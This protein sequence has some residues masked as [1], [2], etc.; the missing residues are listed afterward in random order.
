ML[1]FEVIWNCTKLCTF[2]APKIFWGWL[3]EILDLHYKTEHSSDHGA[4]FCHDWWTQLRDTL[5]KQ[6]FEK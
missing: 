6:N 2:L 5:A 1:K 4:K 3:L